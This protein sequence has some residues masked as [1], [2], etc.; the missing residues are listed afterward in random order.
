VKVPCQNPI[1]C[2]S[3]VYLK[4][5]INAETLKKLNYWKINFKSFRN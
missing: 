4:Y 5:E 1:K 3:A 2:K